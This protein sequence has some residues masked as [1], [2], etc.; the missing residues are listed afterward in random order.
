MLCFKMRVDKHSES[1]NKFN[2]YLLPDTL[3]ELFEVIEVNRNKN[4]QNNI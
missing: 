4:K 2:S 1:E 3:S